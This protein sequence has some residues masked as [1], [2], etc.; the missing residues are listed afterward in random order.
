MF[1]PRR[2]WR[3][4]FAFPRIRVAIE[5]QGYG[6]GHASYMGM[7]SDYEKHN[8]AV[9]YGWYIIYL[10][11]HDIEN[12]DVTIEYVVSLLNAVNQHRKSNVR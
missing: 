1:H 5:I 4:D 11:S 8:E 9:R 7:A 6:H 10:M 2:K 3:F 12:I